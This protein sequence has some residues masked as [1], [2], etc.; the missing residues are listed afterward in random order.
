VWSGSANFTDDAWRLQENNIVRLR[1]PAIAAAFTADFE[2]MWQT[3]TITATGKGLGG[4][5]V[6]GGSAVAWDF[7]PGDGQAID[8]ALT[9][10]VAGAQQR[11]VLA[12]MVLTSHTVLAALVAAVGRGIPVTGIYDSGQMDPIVRQWRRSKAAGTAQALAD[13]LQVAALL[14]K[15]QST[16][17]TPTSDHDFLHHKVVVCDSVVATGSYNFS[18]NAEHNAENHLRISSPSIADRYVAQIRALMKAY[19]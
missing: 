16:P 15:K 10:M 13:F 5:A 12:T 14:A 17:Y 6:V 11:I 19:G 2:Q 1:S 7:A 4:T 3:G 9:A 8:A 18:A